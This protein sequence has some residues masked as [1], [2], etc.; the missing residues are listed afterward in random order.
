MTHQLLSFSGSM[1]LASIC[2][3]QSGASLSSFPPE[4]RAAYVEYEKA[5]FEEARPDRLRET[6]I[7]LAQEP[8]IAGTEGDARTIERIAGIFRELNLEV[9]I[10]TIWPLLAEPISAEVQI[11]APDTVNLDLKEVPLREDKYSSQATIGWNAYSGSGEAAGEVVYA[12]YGRKQDFETLRRLGI[13][14]TGKIVVARYGGNYRGFKAKFAEAAG[15]AGLII[16]TDPADSGY[17]KGLTYPEGGYANDCCIQRGSIMTLGYQGDP[18]TPGI[19]ATRDAKRRDESEVALPRIP[20]QPMG[21]GPVKEILS[22]MKGQ[23]VPDG[24]QGGLPFTYRVTGGDELRVRM[25]VEQ[26]REIKKTANVVATLR[27]AT[28]PEQ[29]VIMGAHHDA[30]NH[31]AADPLCGTIAVIESARAFSKLAAEGKRPARSVVFAAWGAEEFGIIGSTE[32]VEANRANL[33]KN[34]VAY[35]NL[36][37]ASMGPQFGGAVSPSMRAVVADVAATVPAPGFTGTVYEEWSARV[38]AGGGV[39]TFGDIGGGSDH[40]A[41]LCHAGIPSAGFG[42]SGSRGTSYHSAYDTLVWYWRT[43][44]AD[45]G[46]AQMM[47]RMSMGT[48]ARLASAPIIPLDQC[49]AW[50]DLGKQLGDL[51][52]RPPLKEQSAGAPRLLLQSVDLSQRGR[53]ALSRATAHAAAGTITPDELAAV[54]RTILGL[55]RAWLSEA[56]LPERPWFKSLY[57]SPDEDSGYDAWV[58][59]GL[60]RAAERNDPEAAAVGIELLGDALSAQ[61][62]LLDSLTHN[63]NERSE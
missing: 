12:N 32:W 55:E 23:A 41:F 31:G 47:T 59:P 52:Q 34:A 61:S 40:V 57:A 37:M 30:W 38:G 19:E 17:M 29:L 39:P 62:R 22:R 5:L 14:C 63:R 36:D 21:Y 60:R 25:R 24:W 51:M 9:E 58:L 56:G 42:S 53:G 49:A 2:L 20:V 8:H 26:K 50:D 7:L 16:F 4:A 3:A 43:V 33:M 46:P 54:N 27:G 6:H 48:A 44:G 18:L 11:I 28:H 35:I 13:D 45:Y 1:T 10:H 15:A